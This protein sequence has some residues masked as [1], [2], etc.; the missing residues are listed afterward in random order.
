MRQNR[1]Y[2]LNYP[3]DTNNSIEKLVLSDGIDNEEGKV[4]PWKEWK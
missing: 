2:Q 4:V 3:I 1:F